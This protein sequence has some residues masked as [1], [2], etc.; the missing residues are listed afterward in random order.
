MKQ[1]EIIILYTFIYH[2]GLLVQILLTQKV[3][4]RNSIMLLHTENEDQ[5][6]LLAK[7]WES[8]SYGCLIIV[9]L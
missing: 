2:Y 8:L 6:F 1:L 9:T 5:E 4:E 7:I 3:I